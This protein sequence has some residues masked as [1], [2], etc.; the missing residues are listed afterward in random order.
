MEDV[1][2]ELAAVNA[3][4]TIGLC[5]VA[6]LG[7]QM[8]LTLIVP[9]RRDSRLTLLGA[10]TV[11]IGLAGLLAWFTFDPAIRAMKL[12]FSPVMF[13]LIGSL[14]AVILFALRQTRKDIY[15]AVEVAVALATLIILGRQYDQ[16]SELTVIIAFVGAIYVMVRGF[17]NIGE[18]WKADMEKAKAEPAPN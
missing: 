10:F 5:L 14:T 4:G 8:V 13:P 1:Q 16:Q 18:Q 15:G 17:T 11:W 7:V 6:L 3:V 12:V 2:T 9:P